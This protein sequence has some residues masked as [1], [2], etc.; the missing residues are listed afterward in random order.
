MKVDQ[1]FTT[2]LSQPT[3]YACSQRYFR[4]NNAS[5]RCDF[6]GRQCNNFQMIAIKNIND[7]T[8]HKKNITI[9]TAVLKG[10]TLTITEEYTPFSPPSPPIHHHAPTHPKK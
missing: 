1:S 8:N 10:M 4:N 3:F 5:T 9:T 7:N 6:S 2:N